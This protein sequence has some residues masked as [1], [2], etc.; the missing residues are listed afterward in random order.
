MLRIINDFEFV[1]PNKAL[2]VYVYDIYENTIMGFLTSTETEDKFDIIDRAI[3]A[4][5]GISGRYTYVC[6][7]SP[8]EKAEIPSNPLFDVKKEQG[9][10]VKIG[11]MK[12]KPIAWVYF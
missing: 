9:F 6:S 8:D 12:G 11:G 4:V 3:N 7:M 10:I 1:S 2:L 5:Y